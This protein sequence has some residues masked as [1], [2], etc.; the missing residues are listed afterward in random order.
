MSDDKPTR[1]D[2]MKPLQLLGLAFG[3]AVFAGVVTL[4]AMGF[5]QQRSPEQAPAALQLALIFAGVTFIVVLLVVSLLLLAIDPAQVH[6]TIDGPVLLPRDKP[7]GSAGGTN[8]NGTD[9]DAAASGGT[10]I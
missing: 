1:R 2:L 8:A 9:P 7:N 4:V 5:F 10:R 6:K 3:A